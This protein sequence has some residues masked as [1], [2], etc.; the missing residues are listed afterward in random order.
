MLGYQPIIVALAWSVSF[1]YALLP[2]ATA[3]ATRQL[4]LE[5]GIDYIEMELYD[6]AMAE[7]QKVI[8]H[9]PS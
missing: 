7:L 3:N 6:Q 9:H 1:C 2:H 5:R 4:H 8:Q